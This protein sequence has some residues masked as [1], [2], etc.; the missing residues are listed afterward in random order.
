MGFLLII[1][2]IIIIIMAVFL[3][4]NNKKEKPNS[5]KA[6]RTQRTQHQTNSNKM[7]LIPYK[8]NDFIFSKNEYACYKNLKI[9]ADKYNLEIFSKIR[10]AD[11]VAVDKNQTSETQKYFNK[12]KSKHIDFVLLDN[13]YMQPKL[14]IELD[15]N[16]HDKPDRMERDNFVDSICKKCSL[17]ILH[18]RNYALENLENDIKNKIG[19]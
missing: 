15:D 4:G 8:K 14:L 2:V 1:A 18:T 19:I 7:D 9:I 11:L 10:F 17:P 13:K 12:I 6:T 16:S 5:Q 3:T